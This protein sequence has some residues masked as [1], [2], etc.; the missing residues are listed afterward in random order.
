MLTELGTRSAET[1]AMMIDPSVLVGELVS[2]QTMRLDGVQSG[3]RGACE[4]VDLRGY[5]AQMLDVDARR[6]TTE[7]VDHQ[8]LWNGGALHL[9]CDAVRVLQGAFVE[10]APISAQ[11]KRLPLNA[12][13]VR[14]DAVFSKPLRRGR[15]CG[16]AVLPPATVVTGAESATV[17]RATA[18]GDRA[19]T[20]SVHRVN[21]SV[22]CGRASQEPRPPYFT[23][24]LTNAAQ[25]APPGGY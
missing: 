14:S 7:M 12:P 17:K 21:S 16:Q 15:Q 13:A 5:D 20:I 8:S 11:A 22:S 2:A 6:I 24:P 4:R 18:I 10:E 19:S 3:R 1:P 25:I 23:P 9:P